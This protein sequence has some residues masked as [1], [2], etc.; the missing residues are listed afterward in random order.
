MS[1]IK[2]LYASPKTLKLLFFS[3]VPKPLFGN[4]RKYRSFS[5]HKLASIDLHFFLPTKETRLSRTGSAK[6]PPPLKLRRTRNSR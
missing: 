2:G 4:E 3:L 1:N 5:S 6:N